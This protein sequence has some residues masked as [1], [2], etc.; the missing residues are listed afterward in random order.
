MK[1]LFLISII[2]TVNQAVLLDS[3]LDQQAIQS[4]LEQQSKCSW[5]KRPAIYY[6]TEWGGAGTIGSTNNL[7][8]E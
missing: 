4:P 1:N 7:D 2:L 8:R 6:N 5:V 3:I